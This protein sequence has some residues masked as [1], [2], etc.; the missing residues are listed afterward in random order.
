MPSIL[1]PLASRPIALLWSGIALSAMG[2]Q[3]FNIV[4]GWIA[5]DR[6]GTFAGLLPAGQSVVLIATSL[7][8]GRIADR[9][10]LRATLIGADLA[11]AAALALMITLW[12]A[13]GAA[14]GWSLILVVGVLAVGMSFFRPAMQ[15]M[16]PV[17]A[18]RETLPATNALMDMT[19]R[20]ARLIGPGLISLAAAAL[21]LVHFVTLDLVTFLVSALA[22]ALIRL[23]PQPARRVG[24][25]T[26]Q[27][28]LLHGFRVVRRHSLLWLVLR[29]SGVI[30]GAWYTAYFI[31]L[32]L[33]LVQAGIANG[34]AAFGLVIS[35]YGVT[36]LISNL[37]VGSRDVRHRPGRLIFGGNLFVGGGILVLGLSGLLLPPAWLVA[38]CVAAALISAIGGPMQDIT[39]ATLRQT[40]LP[41]ADI[42]A[43]VRAFVVVSQLGSLVG[44]AAS[45]LLFVAAGVPGT[46]LLCAAAMIATGV[47]GLMR[48]KGATPP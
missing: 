47:V 37:I 8:S 38:G 42:P 27:A 1:R 28:S 13:Q 23:P 39:V 33:M 44:L 24:Q 48:R 30:N 21:P 18:D 19:D 5:A 35:A 4:L 14:P 46:V 6:F 36:N 25:M 22:V 9:L 29:V 16:L 7:L 32:P 10:S 2:D 34:V 43:A 40:E 31:G 12:L 3:L 26:I 45:P 17:L 15:A 41:A 11:R 20:L